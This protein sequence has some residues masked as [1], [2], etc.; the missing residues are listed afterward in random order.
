MI[1]FSALSLLYSTGFYLFLYASPERFQ[2]FSEAEIFRLVLR[3]P[4]D[5]L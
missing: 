3:E 4:G 5:E 2:N 1:L